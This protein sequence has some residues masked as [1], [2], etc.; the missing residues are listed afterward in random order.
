MP[1]P[2]TVTVCTFSRFWA[3]IVEA[4]AVLNAVNS[5]AFR[6]PTGV[7]V[8]S[9][10][11]TVPRGAV[12]CELAREDGGAK[13]AP[14]TESTELIVDAGVRVSWAISEVTDFDDESPETEL[15]E[16]FFLGASGVSSDTIFIPTDVP[17]DAGIKSVV[18]PCFLITVRC[19]WY[20]EQ[21]GEFV[22]PVE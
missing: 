12:L 2:N 9:S 21:H 18:T 1:A 16:P 4:R 7:P 8:E 5:S 20:D 10:M 11:V 22:S 15:T 19:G 17:V 13:D 3:I 6:M 14:E